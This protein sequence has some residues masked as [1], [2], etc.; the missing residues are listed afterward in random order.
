MEAGCL[1]VL[2][3]SAPVVSVVLVRFLV[4]LEVLLLGK[5]FSGAGGGERKKAVQYVQLSLN[6]ISVDKSTEGK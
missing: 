6:C 1:Y 2:P 5:V 3:G 4:V